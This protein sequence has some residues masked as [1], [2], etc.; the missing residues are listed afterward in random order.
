MCT[1]GVNPF[2]TMRP[3]AL[4]LTHRLLSLSVQ[5]STEVA[6]LISHP[7]LQEL[8]LS[9]K[10]ISTLLGC[11]NHNNAVHFSF[12]IWCKASLHRSKSPAL[13]ALQPS[14]YTV[15]TQITSQEQSIQGY[16]KH[17]LFHRIVD[18]RCPS[19]RYGDLAFEPLSTQISAA[20]G[21]Q[22][23]SNLDLKPQIKNSKLQKH[24]DLCWWWPRGTI[25]EQC[26]SFPLIAMACDLIRIK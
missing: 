2:N 10:W 15:H 21:E 5:F 9:R 17:Y 16:H 22:E 4:T 7:W 6:I 26:T 23:V 24:Q 13:R 20:E 11:P 18:H 8:L 1:Y 14:L 3:I 25:H 12:I 19:T